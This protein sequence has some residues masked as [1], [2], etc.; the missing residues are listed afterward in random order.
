MRSH[1]QGGD[2][3]MSLKKSDH[4]KDEMTIPESC[5]RQSA[6]IFEGTGKRI[7]A[8]MRRI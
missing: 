4:V 2:A 7:G 1:Y 6:E 5:A 3:T 8:T